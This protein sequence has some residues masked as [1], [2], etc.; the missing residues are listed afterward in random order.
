[1]RR[2]LPAELGTVAGPNCRAGDSG[3]PVFSGTRAYGIV[4]GGSYRRDGT[5]AFYFYMSTDYLP[6][7]WALLGAPSPM[8]NSVTSIAPSPETGQR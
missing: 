6:T 1:M 8:V 3:A 2:R 7:G 4:K 5:C